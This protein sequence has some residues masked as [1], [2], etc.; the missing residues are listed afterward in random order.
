MVQIVI[1]LVTLQNK[2]KPKLTMELKIV[3][4]LQLVENLYKI[5][6]SLILSLGSERYMLITVWIA[7]PLN[8]GGDLS[9]SV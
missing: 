2:T 5:A 1:I 8:F 4:Y 3:Q 9:K 7:I 6:K